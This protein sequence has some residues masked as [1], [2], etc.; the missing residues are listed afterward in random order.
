MKGQVRVL[1]ADRID[2]FVSFAHGGATKPSSNK[3][4]M[5]R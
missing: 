5:L 2:V 4:P 3:E 1:L